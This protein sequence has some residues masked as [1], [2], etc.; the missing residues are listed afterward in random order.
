MEFNVEELL[1]R[2][3]VAYCL[4]ALDDRA[5]TTDDVVRLSNGTVAR[6]EICK[7]LIVCGKNH[8]V[9]VGVLM[10][11]TDRLDF[12]KIG[13]E[14]GEPARMASG[15][16]IVQ[17]SGT[18]IGAVCPWMLSVPLY[19]DEHVMQL[20][21]INTGSGNHEYGIEFAPAELLKL[22]PTV[23]PLAV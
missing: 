16:E 7:T 5:V 22:R 9:C 23:M 4:I 11:G 18:E 12:K 14:I 6:E 15:D 13:K 2:H 19:I 21:R 20:P 8:G 3:G 1:A 17:V 10:R